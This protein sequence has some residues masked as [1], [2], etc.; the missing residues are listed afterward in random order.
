MTIRPM[1]STPKLQPTTVRVRAFCRSR[2]RLDW[3][4]WNRKGCAAPGRRT[5]RAI[6]RSVSLGNWVLSNLQGVRQS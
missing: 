3:A 5:L 1:P 4:T 2:S 6:T